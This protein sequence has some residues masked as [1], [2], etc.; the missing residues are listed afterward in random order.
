MASTV[1]RA[2]LSTVT[3]SGDTKEDISVIEAKVL[4]LANTYNGKV[5]FRQVWPKNSIFL[6]VAFDSEELMQFWENSIGL[7]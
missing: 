1:N 5:V 7:S 2:Y 3:I 4:N 6:A